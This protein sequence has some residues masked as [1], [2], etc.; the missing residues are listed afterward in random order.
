MIFPTINEVCEALANV[1]SSIERGGCDVRLQ[2]ISNGDWAVHSGDASY[3]IDHRGYWGA[4]SINKRDSKRNRR[5][6]AADLIEQAADHAA[7]N[8]ETVEDDTMTWSA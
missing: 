3:D 8:G 4:S 2:V 5:A 6:I 7:Q 1:Q